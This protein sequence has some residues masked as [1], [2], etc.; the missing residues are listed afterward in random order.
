MNTNEPEEEKAVEATPEQTTN[1]KQ[2]A[3]ALEV[4]SHIARLHKKYGCTIRQ[5]SV[6]GVNRAMKR[7]TRSERRKATLYGCGACR[8]PFVGKERCQCKPQLKRKQV[9]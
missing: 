4:I 1:Q 5:V 3:H 6:T 2:V 7:S 8:L 9:A